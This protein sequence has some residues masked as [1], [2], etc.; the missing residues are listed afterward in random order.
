MIKVEIISHAGIATHEVPLLQG[1]QV[2]PTVSLF[3]V[4]NRAAKVA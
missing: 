2:R 4:C 3:G 1:W